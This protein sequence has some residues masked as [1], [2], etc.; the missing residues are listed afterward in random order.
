MDD[1]QFTDYLQYVVNIAGSENRPSKE[2]RALIMVRAEQ[3]SL[4]VRGDEIAI[5]G[6]GP[7]LSVR[8]NYEVA[9]D[10][11][12]FQKTVYTKEFNHYVQYRPAR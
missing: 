2:I 12:V 8:V 11:P 5:I 7:K 3:L 9:I 10:I 1:Q 6:G 4:P